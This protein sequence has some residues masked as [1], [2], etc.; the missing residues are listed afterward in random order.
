MAAGVGVL[1]VGAPTSSERSG[2]SETN[3]L[4]PPSKTTRVSATEEPSS[5]EPSPR[6]AAPAHSPTSAPEVEAATTDPAVVAFSEH[7]HRAA[8]RWDAASAVLQHARPTAYAEVAQSLAARLRTPGLSASERQ[9]V[10]VEERQLVTHLL[11]RYD[12]ID[13]LQAI[14]ADLQADIDAYDEAAVPVVA[15]PDPRPSAGSR[16]Q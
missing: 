7:A 16:P 2:I 14:L 11:E 10:V 6:Q 8:P 9:A 3:P 15:S 5:D 13:E 1:V 4:P 12:G